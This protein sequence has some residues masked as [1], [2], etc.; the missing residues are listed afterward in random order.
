MTFSE[1]A[2]ATAAAMG[3]D[4]SGDVGGFSAEAGS[5]FSGDRDDFGLGSSEARVGNSPFTGTSASAVIDPGWSPPTALWS[6]DPE[7]SATVE[8]PSKRLS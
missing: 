8:G 4:G 7:V 3:A 6:G 2:S 1:A 5:S